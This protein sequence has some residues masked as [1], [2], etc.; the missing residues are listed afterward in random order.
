[1]AAT[2]SERFLAK[3]TRSISASIAGSLMPMRLREPGWSAAAEPQIAAL[4]V[5][6]RQ[7]LAPGAD[8][9]VVVPGAQTV[10]VLRI[11][12]GARASR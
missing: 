7:R 6:R 10:L 11:V 8:D 5:A 12:D 2:S 4:L 1:M 3:I 9:R